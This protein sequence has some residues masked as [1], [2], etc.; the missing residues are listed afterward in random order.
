MAF[1]GRPDVEEEEDVSNLTFPS[2]FEDA[3]FLT[4]AEAGV[5]LER[6]VKADAT[7]LTAGVGR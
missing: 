2:D 4:N 5:L 3:V 7:L 1:V 6:Q